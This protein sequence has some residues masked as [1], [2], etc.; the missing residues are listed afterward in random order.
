MT[1]RKMTQKK[2]GWDSEIQWTKQPRVLGKRRGKR[3]ERWITPSTWKAIDERRALKAVKEQILTAGR[4]AEA[5]TNEY[6]IKDKVV[7]KCCKQNKQNWLDDKATEAEHVAYIGDTKTTYK[8]VKELSGTSLNNHWLYW[9][10]DRE[11]PHN[12]NRQTDGIS[13]SSLSLIALSRTSSM[14]SKMMKTTHPA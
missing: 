1:L 5:I 12:N 4:D 13:T 14:T 10:T 6:T 11:H 3:R 9:Q 8:I 7:K 2:S